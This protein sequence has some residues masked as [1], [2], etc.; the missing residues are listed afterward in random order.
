MK[1]YKCISGRDEDGLIVRLNASLDCV[2]LRID[3][4]DKINDVLL[5]KFQVQELIDQ[6]EKLKKE[7]L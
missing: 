3:E 7:I 6:L 2:H 4:G 5:S 1:K